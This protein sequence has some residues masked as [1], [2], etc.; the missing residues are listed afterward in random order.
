MVTARSIYLEKRDDARVGFVERR[1]VVVV[2]VAAFTL[3]FDV[4]SVH[5]DVKYKV[6]RG[7]HEY[8]EFGHDKAKYVVEEGLVES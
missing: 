8:E 6:D 4:V 2:V 1:C 7:C 3:E 5:S